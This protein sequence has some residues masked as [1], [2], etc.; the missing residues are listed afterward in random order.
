METS[1]QCQNSTT[2]VS[3]CCLPRISEGASCRVIPPHSHQAEHAVVVWHKVTFKSFFCGHFYR[4]DWIY[5]KKYDSIQSKAFTGATVIAIVVRLAS[6]QH[7]TYFTMQSFA[8]LLPLLSDCCHNHHWCLVSMN[9]QAHAI[10]YDASSSQLV[11][12]ARAGSSQKC[13]P[14]YSHCDMAVAGPKTSMNNV[15][16]VMSPSLAKVL[17]TV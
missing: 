1:G 16:A 10:L 9:Q 17:W 14:T 3:S 4:K 2:R 7:R 6:W 13:V 12:H 15:S 5:C 8:P 11:G